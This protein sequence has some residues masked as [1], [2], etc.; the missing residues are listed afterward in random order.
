MSLGG[1]DWIWLHCEKTPARSA[2]DASVSAAT[3]RPPVKPAGDT[4]LT[5]RGRNPVRFLLQNKDPGRR[6]SAG[7]RGEQMPPVR[8]THGDR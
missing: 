6:V 8:P 1:S 5:P 4:F 2:C 7:R 3:L